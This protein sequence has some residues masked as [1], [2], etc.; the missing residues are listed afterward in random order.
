MGFLSGVLSNIKEH[1]GQHR[2]I[3]QPA[4]NILN[5]NKHGGKKGFN[6][7]IE[8]VVK[9]V[10]GYNESVAGSNK[11]VSE[12]MTLILSQVNE[13]FKRSVT[14]ILP[15]ETL[16]KAKDFQVSSAVEKIDKLLQQCQKHAA[17]FNTQLN[18]DNTDNIIKNA[19]NDLNNDL[20]LRVK[21]SIKSVKYETDRM[22]RMAESR[23][24]ELQETTAKIKSVFSN[25]ENCI[26]NKVREDIDKLVNDLKS[27]VQ[28]ILEQLNIISGK[29]KGYVSELQTW[30]DSVTTVIKSALEKVESLLKEVNEGDSGMKPHK[31]KEAAREITAA[32]LI[33]HGAG[34][35]AIQQVKDSVN[36]ALE[37]V[38][39]MDGKLKEDLKK[40][41]DAVSRQVEE[42]KT[43]IGKLYNKINPDHVGEI[44]EEQKKIEAVVKHIHSEVR[45]ID[46]SGGNAR[47]T[48][49]TATGLAGIVSGV[50]WTY[51][52]KLQSRFT[53]AIQQMVQKLA[54]SGAVRKCLSEHITWNQDYFN[55]PLNNEKSL[56][57]K[58]KELSKIV[59]STIT[60]K[61]Q[62]ITPSPTLG[63]QPAVDEVLGGIQMY[64][65]QICRAVDGQEDSVQTDIDNELQRGTFQ[66]RKPSD[67]YSDY[68]LKQAIQN[69]LIAVNAAVGGAAEEFGRFKNDSQI[70]NLGPALAAAE[71]IE[72]RLRQS[73]ARAQGENGPAAAVDSAI[74]EVTRVLGEKLKKDDSDPASDPAK[75]KMDASIFTGYTTCVDQTPGKLSGDIDQLAGTL[76]EKIKDIREKVKS[77]LN[78]IDSEKEYAVKELEKVTATLH[79]L[80]QLVK[81]DGEFA[82][83]NLISLRDKFFNKAEHVKD[84]I[85]RIRYEISELGNKELNDVIKKATYFLSSAEPTGKATITAIGSFVSSNVEEAQKDLITKINKNY[86]TSVQDMLL[87]FAEKTKKELE[88]LPK[89]ITD[90]LDIG[91]KGFMKKFE[92]HF[93]THEKSIKT[94]K[95]INPKPVAQEKSPMSQAAAKFFGSLNRFLHDLEKQPDFKTDYEKIK[96]TR[97]ALA[98]LFGD[99]V[100]SEYFNHEFS[101]N[102]SALKVTLS[103]LK[104][105]LYGEGNTPSLLNALK[106]GFTTSATELNNAYIS[107]YDSERFGAELVEKDK[108]TAYGTKLSKVCLTVVSTSYN[109]LNTVRKYSGTMW[110]S[111]KI[112]Q[113]TPIG[114]FLGNNGYVVSK[115]IQ[116]GQ[117]RNGDGMLGWHV[118]KSLVKNADGRVYRHH[119]ADKDNGPLKTLH[120]CLETYYE[121]CHQSTFASKRQPSSVFEMLCWLCGLP[122]NSVYEALLR[123]TMSDLFEDPKKQTTEAG[124]DHEFTL[125]TPDAL[126]LNAYPSNITYGNSVKA[127]R[128]LCL[129]SYDLLTAILGTG[130][131]YSMY[132]VDFCNNSHN[133][134]Y[135]QKG[136]DCL[137]M[138]LDILRSLLPSLNFLH[139]Q[140][141]LTAEHRGWSDCWYGKGVQSSKSQ[142]N[143]HSTGKAACQADGQ[144]KCQATCQPTSPLQSYLS[145]CL[146]GH[147]PH[148]VSSIGC[149]AKCATCPKGL[150]GQPC[151]TPL[152]F[153]GFSG[154]MKTGEDLCKAL[155]KFF[156]NV[157]YSSLLCLMPKPPSTLPEHFQ[158]VSTLARVLENSK[159][160]NDSAVKTA[161]ETA[162]KEMSIELYNDTSDFTNALRNAYHSHRPDGHKTYS[163]A[164]L[165]TL[166]VSTPC[167]FASSDKIHCAPYLRA[168]CDDSYTY[169]AEKHSELYFSWALYLPLALYDCLKSL[170]D[171]FGNISCRDWGCS[172]CT[173]GTKCSRGKHGMENCQ[174]RGIVECRGVSST[175]YS[176]GFTFRDSTKLHGDTSKSYCHHFYI[177]LKNVLQSTHFTALF[178]E[179]DEFLFT[180]REP[181]IWLNVALWSLSLF[182]LICVMVG[183]LDVLHIRSHLRIPSSHKITAQSLLAAAQVGRLAKISYLQP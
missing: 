169:L 92:K 78:K 171:S 25:V 138:L 140:C 103:E 50:K 9:G 49:V 112:N 48:T 22:N 80:C 162:T 76:P 174:C 91:Y 166:S 104:P 2:D 74:T 127:V 45:A 106:N 165:S 183:R 168:L 120:N 135:P 19:I 82:K 107:T 13:G 3:I 137:Q 113:S 68:Y 33:L 69:I 66:L 5:K 132:A 177:Q 99:L 148:Q 56:P 42:I 179:C 40:V 134:Y 167:T 62:A 79:D 97:D 130:D 24:N 181:F 95:D 116:D 108:L 151:I 57:G 123:D 64:L 164:D 117:L 133:F 17:K 1:L 96:P 178:K 31:I 172:R 37:Q 32:V 4:I 75:V 61:I 155:T 47:R 72:D 141:K 65:S 21:N 63:S 180:I 38:K 26:N 71:R 90:D 36:T 89:E 102:L 159:G 128:H 94:I 20:S 115:D 54:D 182:Y 11:K 125:V 170:L 173:H 144:P 84:S 67:R 59:S 85:N 87:E 23:Q 121:V 8:S 160:V 142:C 105:S 161:F 146:T 136:D 18:I 52:T 147:L 176:Y 145:D 29:L 16:S 110:R 27:R 154:G 58:I 119:D 131:A 53:E 39:E 28:K 41:K 93:V 44:T 150:P 98:K 101:R 60:N 158:F 157:Q 70:T 88:L 114:H 34:E 152:G 51:A 12:P 10:R 156:V 15:Q 86:V 149:K 81:S 126:C 111:D 43:A 83:G 124:E 139:S 118:Y 7:A 153:R 55:K 35:V 129:R 163:E 46:G 100:T 77:A 109:V 122:C 14:E 175:F 30:I 143:D 6:A 73:Y